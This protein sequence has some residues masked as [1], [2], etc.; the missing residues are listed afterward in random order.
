MIYPSVVLKLKL[1]LPSAPASR[2]LCVA[3][4]IVNSFVVTCVSCRVVSSSSSSSSS[5]DNVEER[6]MSCRAF[7]VWLKVVIF[8]RFDWKSFGQAQDELVTGHSPRLVSIE[9]V[10]DGRTSWP[11]NWQPIYWAGGNHNQNWELR[12]GRVQLSST[13]D[14]CCRLW[15]AAKG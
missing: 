9:W 3:V 8:D 4:S 7:W 1:D 6:K 14:G 15:Q 13:L 2:L 10:T 12:T 11:A 5:S